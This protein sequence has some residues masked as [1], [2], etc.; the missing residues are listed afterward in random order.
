MNSS[1]RPIYFS[2]KLKRTSAN[3]TSLY[4]VRNCAWRRRKHKG[5]QTI[6]FGLYDDLK[7]SQLTI[8]QS[9]THLTYSL[10]IQQLLVANTS[11][12]LWLRSHRISGSLSF[13]TAGSMQRHRYWWTWQASETTYPWWR[14]VSLIDIFSTISR[15]LKQNLLIHL[16]NLWNKF[17]SFRCNFLALSPLGGWWIN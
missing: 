3:F 4:F 7:L 15:V 10:V 12:R 1:E 13:S 8:F 16:L 14:Q 9:D 6:D 5:E 11:R 17:V 2:R